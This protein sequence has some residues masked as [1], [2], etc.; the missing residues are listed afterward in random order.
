MSNAFSVKQKQKQYEGHVVEF[1]TT[2]HGHFLV[3]SD[4]HSFQSVLRNT[5]QKYL[6]LGE[7][8]MTTVTSPDHILRAIRDTFVRK[9]NILVFIERVLQ[10]KDMALLIRQIKNAYSSVR[11][12]V[13]TGEVDQKRLILLHEIGA[14]NFIAKPISV[15]MLLEKI[16]FTIKPQSKLGELI[17]LA[18]SMVSRGSYDQA[19]KASR[20]ILEIKPNSAAGLLVMGDAYRG[21]KKIDKASQCYEEA[22][23]HAQMF[24]EPIKKLSTLYAETG[25]REKQLVCL[26]RLD[27]LSPLNVERKVDMGS[28]HVELGNVDMAEML[29]EVAIEQAKREAFTYI[30]EISAK[31][32]QAYA[33][34]EPEKAEHY[35]RQA[36]ETKGNMLDSSDIATFTRL[37]IALRKQGKWQ[38]ACDEY[39]KALAIAPTDEN[40]YYNMALAFAEGKQHSRAAESVGMALHYNSGLAKQDKM[41]A[42]NI[43]LIYVLAHKPEQARKML[44]LAILLD[45]GF[46]KAKQLLASIA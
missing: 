44:E 22:Q 2:K 5:L 9:K 21:L 17:D 4:D 32:A 10:G 30:G 29:F 1:A 27:A 7:G 40:L 20:K 38:E 24:L 26:E 43:G 19:L 36:L 16:A 11:V 46:I 42:Y 3:V 13:L 23:E 35:Y 34:T 25:D 41:I 39:R 12:I 45:D 6:A 31:I 14:D 33:D 37:G 15:N 28:I 8:C 18:K